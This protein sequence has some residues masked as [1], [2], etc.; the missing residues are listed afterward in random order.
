MATT[1]AAIAIHSVAAEPPA[2]RVVSSV[3]DAGRLDP[4]GPVHWTTSPSAYVWKAGHMRRVVP[5]FGFTPMKG[6]STNRFGGNVPVHTAP[7]IFPAES[8]ST[9]R[10]HPATS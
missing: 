10:L 3:D 7:V 8:V 9:W 4:S 6:N 1:S 2:E 5:D